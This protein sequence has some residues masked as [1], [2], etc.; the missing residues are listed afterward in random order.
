MVKRAV[1]ELVPTA[2]WW[3][4]GC[5]V[6]NHPD[7][8]FGDA[9]VLSSLVIL[10]VVDLPDPNI[11]LMMVQ[12]LQAAESN[13]GGGCAVCLRVPGRSRQ[14]CGHY[15]SAR[16]QVASACCQGY[17]GSRV[18]GSCSFGLRRGDPMTAPR[19]TTIIR[20]ELE[21]AIAYR[22]SYHDRPATDPLVFMMRSANEKDISAL[23]AELQVAQTGD[24]EMTLL[25]PDYEHHRVSVR[26]ITR[27]LET[28]QSSYRAMYKAI[29]PT[30]SIKRSDA[31][32]SLIATAPGSYKV[33]IATPATQLELLDPPVADLALGAIVELLQSAARGTTAIDIPRWVEASEEPVVRSMIRFSVALAGSKGSTV[34]RWKGIDS[35][36][37]MVRISSE[38]ARALAVSLSGESGREILEVE[39]HLEMG[40]DQPPRIRIR[41]AHDEYLAAVPSEE[42]LDQVKDLLFGEVHATL[43]VDMR[44]SATTGS[45]ETRTELL[46]IEST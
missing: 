19:P 36:E 41:T 39:G 4:W 15:G 8:L 45:P 12:F 17:R 14:R 2:R 6:S 44:T 29:T 33:Q 22:E 1:G 5:F 7:P 11:T 3:L 32:L 9:E 16:L 10:P 24:L 38:A 18:N 13:F 26:Y 21:S 40:Q 37:R 43:V 35:E 23:T 30:G 28:L 34:V 20:N 31:T 42:L 25:G 46:D 27:V